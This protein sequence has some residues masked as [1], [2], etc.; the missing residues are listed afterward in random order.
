[1]SITPAT[2]QWW[3]EQKNCEAESLI[4]CCKI[5]FVEC[6]L[7]IRMKSDAGTNFISEKLRQDFC[8]KLNI[9]QVVSSSYHHQSNDQVEACIQFV[10][11][12]M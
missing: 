4:K 12:T 7:P 2:C 8:M 5:K 10:K 3:S 6:G 11:W 1:M 9:E